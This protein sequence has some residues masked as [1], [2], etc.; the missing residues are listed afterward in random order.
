MKDGLTTGNMRKLWGGLLLGVLVLEAVSLIRPQRKDS[1]SETV[2]DA[3]QVWEPLPLVVGMVAGHWF[4]K[5]GPLALLLGGV[6]L[7]MALWPI[8][9]KKA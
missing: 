2:D 7:G 3:A 6:G 4:P 8:G 5:P 9:G 1:L